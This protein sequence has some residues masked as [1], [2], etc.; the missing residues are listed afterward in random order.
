VA[1][2]SEA[3][4]SLDDRPSAVT[5]AS[6]RGEGE[7]IAGMHGFLTRKLGD[8]DAVISGVARE[9]M[10]VFLDRLESEYDF[11]G[12]QFGNEVA[13]DLRAEF[14]RPL[15]GAAGVVGPLTMRVPLYPD[16]A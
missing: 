2:F 11:V 16:P 8:A 13:I 1:S 3:V 14:T 12:L 9:R 10:R 6:R 7:G 5:K 15:P 4:V